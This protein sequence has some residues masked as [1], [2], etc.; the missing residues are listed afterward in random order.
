MAKK[1]KI[2]RLFIYPKCNGEFVF[3]SAMSIDPKA[4]GYNYYA[5]SNCDL[6]TESH[7]SRFKSLERVPLKCGIKRNEKVPLEKG[8]K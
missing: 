3:Y 4:Q 2:D 5:C 7:Y 8:G 6:H 1:R